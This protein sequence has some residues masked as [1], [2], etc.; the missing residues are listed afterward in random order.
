LRRFRIRPTGFA[1]VRSSPAFCF[2]SLMLKF[3]GVLVDNHGVESRRDRTTNATLVTALIAERPT[4]LA[5]IAKAC[6][7]SIT[8]AE[9]VLS[10][11]QRALDVHRQDPSRCQT[12]GKVGALFSVD[13]PSS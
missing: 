7:L 3:T 8:A 1:N 13:R 5:C 2:V 10:V 12:C 9:T 4:C 6:S 11:I